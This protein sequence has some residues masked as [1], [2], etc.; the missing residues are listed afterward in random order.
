MALWRNQR[1]LTAPES[2]LSASPRTGTDRSSLNESETR[3]VT[4]N[5][6][7]CPFL[8]S[9]PTFAFGVEFGLLYARMQA[10]DDSIG[11]YFTIQNQDQILLAASRLGWSVEEMRPWGKD[12]F[13][14]RLEKEPASA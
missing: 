8:N 9:D 14:C 12:W 4:S 1:T 5:T 2:V 6:L 10:S 13:W 11:Q 3:E 7:V